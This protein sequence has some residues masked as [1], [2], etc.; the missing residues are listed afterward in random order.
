MFNFSPGQRNALIFFCSVLAIL[1]VTAGCLRVMRGGGPLHILFIQPTPMEP[2]RSQ[3]H[4]PEVSSSPQP[5]RLQ[6]P[7]TV[8]GSLRLVVNVNRASKMEL[9]ALPGVGFQL[10]SRIVGY[11]QSHGAFHMTEDLLNVEGIGTKNL[12]RIRPYIVCGPE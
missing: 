1:L 10:A 11:R 12:E 3:L 8:P 2:P 5:A 9:E 4:Q 7:R 6:A